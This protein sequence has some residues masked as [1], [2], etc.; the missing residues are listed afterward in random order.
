[1]TCSIPLI[2]LSV[3]LNSEE[4]EEHFTR[5]DRRAAKKGQ[6]MVQTDFGYVDKTLNSKGIMVAYH[7]SKYKKKIKLIVFP[8]FMIDEDQDELW[9]PSAGN[10]SKFVGKLEKK[11]D[12]YFDSSLGL[13]HFDIARV[14]IAADIG[15]G[16]QEK[17]SDHLK[18]MGNIGYVKNFSPMKSGKRDKVAKTSRK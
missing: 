4:Y 15:V 7:D 18:L 14:I 5:A 1:M 6:L 11:I 16:S 12:A 10:I 13:H 3:V 2:E 8:C 17:V 9:K